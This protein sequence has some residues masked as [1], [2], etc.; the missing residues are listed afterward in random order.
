MMKKQEIIEN[1]LEIAEGVV[2][3]LVD[4]RIWAGKSVCCNARLGSKKIE[5]IKSIE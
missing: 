4:E 1:I 2:E 5:Q 3:E